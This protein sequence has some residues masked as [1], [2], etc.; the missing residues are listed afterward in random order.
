[1]YTITYYVWFVL[2]VKLL[3]TQSVLSIMKC[4]MAVVEVLDV[5]ETTDWH[6]KAISLLYSWTQANGIILKTS[7]Y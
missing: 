1:M 3:S 5:D 2:I 6:W 7:I 4:Y